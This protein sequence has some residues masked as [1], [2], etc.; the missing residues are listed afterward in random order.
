MPANLEAQEYS[1][2][3]A[4]DA[5]GFAHAVLNKGIEIDERGT[6]TFDLVTSIQF[7][8]ANI[9]DIDASLQLEIVLI[10]MRTNASNEN[11][12][13]REW[14]EETLLRQ[15]R[16]DEWHPRISV[17]DVICER[18]DWFFFKLIY[19]SVSVGDNL[20]WRSQS[21]NRVNTMIPKADRRFIVTRKQI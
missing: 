6:Y 21:L 19:E 20:I 16:G 8:S 17:P 2:F 12:I 3:P 10:Q 9:V 4:G 11:I 13:V 15:V 5:T 14:P 18:G 7:T 1:F